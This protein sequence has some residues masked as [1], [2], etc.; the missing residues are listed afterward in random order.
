[1]VARDYEEIFSTGVFTNSGARERAFAGALARWIANDVAVSVTSSATAGIQLACRALFA[2][3]RPYVLVAS[4][5]FAAGPLALRWC[6]YEPVFLDIDRATWQPDP[7]VAERFLND[8]ADHVAGILL[9]NTFGTANDAIERWEVVARRYELPLV[10]DSAAGFASEYSWGE[11][12]GARGDCEIF[13]FHATKIVA[14]GEGGAVS[15][16]DHDLIDRIDRLKNFGFDMARDSVDVGTNAKLPELAS[17][18]GLRQLEA[19]PERLG[20]RRE[21]LEWYVDCFRPVGV[22][23]QPGVK[24]SAPPFVSAVLP[25]AGCR[26]RVGR[27]LDDAGIGWRTYYN[28]PVHRQRSFADSR[29][30]SVLPVTEEIASRIISLPLQDD[31]YAE[32]VARIASVVTEA[33]HK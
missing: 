16:R 15:A 12:L 2:R 18:I 30:A 17:A 4:F 24:S 22:E 8:E 9:T 5:T 10:I 23:L 20:R 32:V 13:S 27:A 25:T 28:P 7:G 33:I 1:V 26:D 21:V 3:D 31:L 6:G 14:V 29:S 11:R 19:L